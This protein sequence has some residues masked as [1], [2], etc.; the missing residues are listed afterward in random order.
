MAKKG[1]T[2]QPYTEEFKRKAV[3]LYVNGEKSYQILAN[4]L[5][6]RSPTQLKDWVKKHKQGEPLADQ[7]GGESRE[8]NPFHRLSKTTFK[9]IEKERDYLKA[10]VE[11]LKKQLSKS[12]WEGWVPKVKRFEI[13]HEL[14]KNYPITWLVT[15]AGVSRSGYYKWRE[16][17]KVR[18]KR[19]QYEQLLKKHLMA[20]HHTRP[21]YGCPRLQIALKKEGFHVNHKRVYRL[22]KEL[23]I[24]SVIR[25]KRRFF[26]RKASI[27]Q[28]NRLNRVFKTNKPNRLYVT[29][30][31]YLDL[32][33]R[34]YYLSA[35]QD[36]FNNEIV[37][38]ELS[39]RNDLKLVSDTVKKLA[40]TREVQ[41]AIL[42]SDQGFQYTSKTYNDQI[43]TFGIIGSH[44]RKGNCLDN[45]CIESFFSHVKTE[46]MYFSG[47]K[48]ENDLYRAIE[49]YIWFYNHERF[50]KKL[51]Q[52]API[53]Y[54]NTLIA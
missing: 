10:Q 20:I 23:N 11:Y 36:L 16:T 47:C 38:W 28:P 44:S 8:L 41:G 51:N 4:E 3:M 25:K 48:T 13:I 12:T 9:S 22:M 34:F 18:R 31:T 30:I 7:R 33:D 50:Q 15:I 21:F 52:C 14:H 45:A 29:D 35:I 37:A 46:N 43:K 5:G 39:K 54:R 42:H 6:L 19:Y 24:R 27:I 32:G 40:T 53:E 1:Q 2:F 49:D 26:G 17:E